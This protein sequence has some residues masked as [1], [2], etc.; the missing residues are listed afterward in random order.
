V[1]LGVDAVTLDP[2]LVLQVAN[3]HQP[4]VN[5]VEDRL[6]VV[7]ALAVDPEPHAEGVAKLR[8]LG[9]ELEPAPLGRRRLGVASTETSRSSVG[10]IE[11]G[12][13]AFGILA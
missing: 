4:W 5:S 8:D 6:G 10:P 12:V 7:V 9:D 2:H 13:E 3:P 1:K 11:H